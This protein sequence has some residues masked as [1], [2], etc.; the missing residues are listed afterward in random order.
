MDRYRA[1]I[2]RVDASPERK[3]AMIRAVGAL[4][5]TF[6][7]IA[8]GSDSVQIIEQKRIKDSFQAAT[9]HVSLTAGESAEQIDLESASMNG[10]ATKGAIT[11]KQSDDLIEKDK[12][13]GADS[14]TNDHEGSHLLP[15]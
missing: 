8:F 2:A 9:L 11:T 14:K 12:R 5:Q 10:G 3:D 15:R 13:D 4:M 7:D 6:V 1:L